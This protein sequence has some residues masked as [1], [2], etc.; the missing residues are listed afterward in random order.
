MFGILRISR[1][2]TLSHCGRSVTNEDY[3]SQS[4]IYLGVPPLD[5]PHQPGNHP[6]LPKENQD[7][8]DIINTVCQIFRNFLGF[9]VFD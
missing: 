3:K 9:V 8:L 5:L 2:I 6:T 1:A 7:Y 4:R